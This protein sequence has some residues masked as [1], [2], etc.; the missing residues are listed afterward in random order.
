MRVRVTIVAVDKQLVLH[1]LSV[2]VDLVMQD[3]A[4][5]FSHTS[6]NDRDVLTQTQMV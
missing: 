3:Y 4:A 5:L 6:L 1:I 2:S